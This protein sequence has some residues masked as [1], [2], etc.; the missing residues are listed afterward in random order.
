M[1]RGQQVWADKGLLEG[2]K[3]TVVGE[4]GNR[5]LVQISWIPDTG[6]EGTP[7]RLHVGGTEHA[8]Q[9]LVEY[10]SGL[11]SVRLGN[12]IRVPTKNLSTDLGEWTA[13]DA[14]W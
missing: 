5:T 8:P 12:V 13:W 1:E 10:P 7:L 6:I 11:Q 9:I 4:E 2:L 3:G 14:G